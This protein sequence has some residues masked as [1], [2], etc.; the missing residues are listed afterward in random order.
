MGRRLRPDRS[1]GFVIGLGMAAAL[2]SAAPAASPSHGISAGMLNVEQ[3]SPIDTN[4]N[5]RVT[6]GLGI[7]TFRVGSYNRA[8][9]SVLIGPGP[10]AA[11]D[12]S[13]GV[14]LSCVTENGRDN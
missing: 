11:Q 9:Y 4:N 7:G 10:V 14:L 8:D 2:L 1:R 13:L 5:A 6:L 12:E 3:I